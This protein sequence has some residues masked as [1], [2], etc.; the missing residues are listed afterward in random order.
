ML[1]TILTSIPIWLYPLFLGL[2]WVGLRASRARRTRPILLYALP[3]LGGLSLSRALSLAQVES[4]LAAL[5]I[6]YAV[7]GLI[8]YRFQGRWIAGRDAQHVQLRGEWV[9]MITAMGLFFLNFATGM[10]QGMAP[11]ILAGNEAAV[12]FG[13]V[14]GLLS[15]SLAGRALRVAIWPRAA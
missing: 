12:A 3:L 4:A 14:A 1:T 5:L 13:T 9:T 11:A 2:I 15:G 10:A 6:A 8:G 7:G